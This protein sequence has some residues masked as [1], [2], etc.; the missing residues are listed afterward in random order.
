[1]GDQEQE[2]Q[3]TARLSVPPESSSL[4]SE[5]PRVKETDPFLPMGWA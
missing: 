3:A 5:K 2:V 1:M 4:L